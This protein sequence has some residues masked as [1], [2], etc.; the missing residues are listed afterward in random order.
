MNN[1]YN[2][3]DQDGW[4]FDKEDS[5]IKLEYKIDDSGEMIAIR[6]TGEGDIPI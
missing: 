6:I 1:Y 5:G 2:E 4:E 3:F